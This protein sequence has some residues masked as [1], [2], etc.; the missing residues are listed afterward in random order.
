M[1]SRRT[2]KFN[3]SR[4]QV[5]DTLHR[6][7]GNEFEI[8]YEDQLKPESGVLSALEHLD[9]EGDGVDLVVVGGVGERGDFVEE[10]R[11]PWASDEDDFSFFG[12]VGPA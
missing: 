3:V 6:R 7:S 2:G 9:G 1:D 4:F 5:N 12:E 8:S 11:D 10:V